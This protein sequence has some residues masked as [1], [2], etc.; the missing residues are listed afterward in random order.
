MCPCYLR[1]LDRV[2]S[3]HV[4]VYCLLN[5]TVCDTVYSCRVDRWTCSAHGMKGTLSSRETER[6]EIEKEK[7]RKEGSTA[8]RT[9]RW[10]QIDKSK[11]LAASMMVNLE[12]FTLLFSCNWVN[13]SFSASSSLHMLFRRHAFHGETILSRHD[14]SSGEKEKEREDFAC[15]YQDAGKPQRR[16]AQLFN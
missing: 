2:L 5:Y 16:K 4:L 3:C 7:E 10:L 1:S 14:D 8:L 9:H 12:L 15:N 13:S 11:P 6:V